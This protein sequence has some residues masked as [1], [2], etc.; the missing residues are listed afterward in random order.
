MSLRFAMYFLCAASCFAQAGVR[1]QA[2]LIGNGQYKQ[3]GKIPAAEKNVRLFAEVL[4]GADFEVT[5]AS[6]VTLD[7]LRDIR[8][9]FIAKLQPGA[10]ALIYYS[11][12]AV[13]VSGDNFLLPVD[14]DPTTALENVPYS[15][16]SLTR[17][18]QLI[19]EKKPL[20]KIEV[21]DAPW[22]VPGGVVRT[23]TG[24]S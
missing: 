14:Y 9:A 18:Q 17:I 22:D 6:N 15:A 24:L 3:L 7:Q 8:T 23:G 16:Q 10:V 20:L 21:L 11:G 5:S 12:F 13:Q 19:D 1:R 2:L 4:R